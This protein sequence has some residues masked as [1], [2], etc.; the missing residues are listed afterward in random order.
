MAEEVDEVR[1]DRL[2]V[3]IDG[4]ERQVPIRLVGLDDGDDLLRVDAQ[5]RVADALHR[6]EQL[7]RQPLGRRRVP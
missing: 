7:D 6:L 4:F 1:G 2:R 3:L 5:V